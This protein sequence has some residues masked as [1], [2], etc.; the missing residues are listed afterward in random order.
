MDWQNKEDVREYHRKWRENNRGKR[1]EYQRNSYQRNR[2]KYL[3]YFKNYNKLKIKEGK[4]QKLFRSQYKKG[5]IPK[6]EHCVICN[7]KGTE[8]HHYD[9]DKP[10]DVLWVCRSCHQ[11]IHQGKTTEEILDFKKLK[12]T[13]TIRKLLDKLDRFNKINYNE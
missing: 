3:L 1:R 11:Y 10:F 6:L 8:A 12:L 5:L 9:Y 4:A 2:S 13:N 7:V